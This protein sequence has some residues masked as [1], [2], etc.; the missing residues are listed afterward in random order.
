ML[1]LERSNLSVWCLTLQI[2]DA[3]NS[4]LAKVFELAVDAE[5]QWKLKNREERAEYLKKV[6]SNPRLKMRSLRYD[7][8]K[9]FERLAKMK[10]TS[11]WRREV[12]NLR[13]EAIAWA[14]A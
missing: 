8:E 3:S 7:L 6:L 13:T 5:L 12:L 4:A 11:N 2:N 10:G 14:S 1:V 9:P